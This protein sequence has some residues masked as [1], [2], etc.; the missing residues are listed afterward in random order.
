MLRGAKRSIYAKAIF[1]EEC[2]VTAHM[3][4]E[5]DAADCVKINIA[6]AD[7]LGFQPSSFYPSKNGLC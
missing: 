7:E 6:G 3:Q 1:I 5:V 2:D 4:N